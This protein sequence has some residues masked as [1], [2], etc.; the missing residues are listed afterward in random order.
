MK[1]LKKDSALC[2]G[3]CECEKTCSLTWFKEDND[4][5]S[6]IRIK[7]NEDLQEITVCSQCGECI[8]ICPVQAI[9]RDKTGV[10]RVK[11]DICVGCFMC[12]GFCPE[13]AMFMHEDYIEPFKCTACGQC[14]K[15]CPS[16][17]LY[18]AE[19]QEGF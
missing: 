6:C 15:T 7:K 9:Y 8:N 1:Y 19:K 12:V 2:T 16:G 14:A 11:K 17:A 4:E 13:G 18:I 10:V 3:C 5:K